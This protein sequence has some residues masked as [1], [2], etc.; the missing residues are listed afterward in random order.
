VF[1]L[2]YVSASITMYCVRSDVRERF[3]YYDS[4]T[5]TQPSRYLQPARHHSRSSQVEAI[6]PQQPKQR[7]HSSQAAVAAKAPQQPKQRSHSSQ[8]KAKAAR[9]LF[10]RRPNH[11]LYALL[12]TCRCRDYPPL[13]SPADCYLGELYW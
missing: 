7:S 2:T 12:L 8:A 9:L 6:V 5:A 1:S 11:G 4:A 13:Q 3:H 10:L